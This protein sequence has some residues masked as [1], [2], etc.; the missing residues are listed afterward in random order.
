MDYSVRIMR[1][2]EQ[3]LSE[4][5]SY[6]SET[7]MNIQA[8]SA[9]LGEFQRYTDMLKTSPYAFPLSFDP[10]LKDEGY[11]KFIF[12]KN[13]VSLYLIDDMK[14]E[15]SIMRIFYAKRDYPDLV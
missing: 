10:R 3:D 12:G 6:I 11:H 1:K 2:A 8:A 14:A 13:F 9:L 5:V 4:I 7:L 15:V